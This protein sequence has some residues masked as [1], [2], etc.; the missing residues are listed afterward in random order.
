MQ[1][2]DHALRRWSSPS[3]EVLR[4]SRVKTVLSM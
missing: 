4:D 3:I 2:H 1:E